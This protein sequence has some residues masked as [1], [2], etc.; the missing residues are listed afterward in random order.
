LYNQS[1][2]IPTP[3]DQTLQ[4]PGMMSAQGGMPQTFSHG[5]HAKPILAHFSSQEL[6]DIGNILGHQKT[7]PNG[8]RDLSDLDHILHDPH[9]RQHLMHAHQSNRAHRAMGGSLQD[10]ASQ[11]RFGDN[12]LAAITPQTQQALNSIVGQ[13]T[14]NPNT[15]HPE[16]PML[17]G[18]FSGLSKMGGSLARGASTLGRGLASG[19]SRFAS[20]GI[21]KTLGNG[22]SQVAKHAA[23]AL[24]N[25]LVG[26]LTNWAQGGGSFGDSMKEGL[27]TGAQGTFNSMAGDEAGPSWLRNAGNLGNTGLDM[28]QARQER[29]ARGEPEQSWQDSLKSGVQNHL[30]Q[31]MD[32]GLS[33]MEDRGMMPDWARPAAHGARDFVNQGL[34][35][36]DWEGAGRQF[37]GNMYG[38]GMD[39]L[40]QQAPEEY[41]DMFNGL[42]QAGQAGISGQ[43]DWRQG[44]SQA[45]RG[46]ASALNRNAPQW[47]Q[48]AMQELGDTGA[49]MFDQGING[50]DWQQAGRQGVARA[51]QRY[52]QPQ[53][54]GYGRP[55]RP[56]QQQQ[57]YGDYP[58]YDQ[59]YG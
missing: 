51:A 19:A 37:A 18:L 54:Q 30:P 7:G 52:S 42:R 1:S 41:G 4:S 22:I 47:A 14:M 44:A 35:G 27:K 9:V 16:Y 21:G 12:Q 26:G 57:G 59:N 24:T 50:G 32:R 31:V 48:P 46:G 40:R 38:Q 11:G 53:Q 36:G 33:M 55:Q 3:Y 2:N 49:D 43:G 25:G 23:P 56:Q 6:H 10:M 29:Q 8:I 15:G 39:R 58:S 34:Q 45:V 5:G 20:S 17:S 13:P 28:Y